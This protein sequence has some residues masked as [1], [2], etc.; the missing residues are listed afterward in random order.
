MVLR[1]GENKKDNIFK[2][3][4]NNR[5]IALESLI[6]SK[7]FDVSKYDIIQRESVLIEMDLD[8]ELRNRDL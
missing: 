1:K 3:W 8:R 4:S 2:D 5:L 7:R 6:N